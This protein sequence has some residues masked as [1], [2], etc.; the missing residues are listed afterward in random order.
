MDFKSK[1]IAIYQE[2]RNGIRRW[3]YIVGEKVMLMMV[4]LDPNVG[5]PQ[6]THPQ[7]QISFILSG[8]A[9][10]RTSEGTYVFNEGT[11][12]HFKPNEP[13]ETRNPGPEKLIVLEVFAPP[14]EDLLKG[15]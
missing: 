9:E 13:H 6:H 8:K 11:A 1:E 14:R 12:Y 7:E 2:P 15:R 3:I 5:I 10:V 4:E